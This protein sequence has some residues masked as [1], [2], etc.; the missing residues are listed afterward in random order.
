MSPARRKLHETAGEA[1]DAV[2]A[3]YG[4]I[5]LPSEADAALRA[6]LLAHIDAAMA[7]RTREWTV[8]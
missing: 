6:R 7:P 1:L 8:T 4:V 5:R 3:A 2:A